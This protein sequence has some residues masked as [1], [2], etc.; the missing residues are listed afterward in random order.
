MAAVTG[1]PAG[2]WKSF[3]LTDEAQEAVK[4]QREEDLEEAIEHYEEREKPKEA[5]ELA[6][7]LL[8]AS[9]AVKKMVAPLLKYDF[10]QRSLYEAWRRCDKEGRDF[11]NYV[12]GNAELRTFLEYAADEV[13]ADP[14]RGV[15]L[16]DEWW[17]QMRRASELDVE[18]ALKLKRK[19]MDESKTDDTVNWMNAA[20]MSLALGRKKFQ[21]KRYAKALEHFSSGVDTMKRVNYESDL[22]VDQ[23]VKLLSNQALASLRLEKW[24]LCVEACDRILELRNDPKAC[25]RRGV[26]F[27]RKGNLADATDS[28]DAAKML[29]EQQQRVGPEED[30]EGHGEDADHLAREV[31]LRDVHKRL[32][33]VQAAAKK[34]RSFD[35]NMLARATKQRPPDSKPVFAR[36]ASSRS[37]SASKNDDAP[38]FANVD[39]ALAF[40][41]L[42][43]RIFQAARPEKQPHLF[44]RHLRSA[45]IALL[46]RFAFPAT[47]AGLDAADRALALHMDDDRV[48]ANAHAIVAA[49]WG[50]NPPDSL[51]RG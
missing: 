40:Q 36:A 45:Q 30:D 14:A 41:A 49:L 18:K 37:S 3:M 25:Y 33:E 48:R 10:A 17:A 38:L 34:A 39:A 5:A 46:P 6:K 28:F 24:T 26:A 2:W 21:E 43:L 1:D 35:R 50:T 20:S 16:N 42:Q 47:P 4:A 11:S 13:R 15:A 44:R 7:A 9:E 8:G 19:N 27:L 32:R 29:L 23:F 51:F 31:A 22:V 12:E